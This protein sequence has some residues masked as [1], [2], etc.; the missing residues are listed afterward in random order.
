[1]QHLFFLVESELHQQVKRMVEANGGDVAPWLRQMLR[2]VSVADFP[3]SWHAGDVPRRKVSGDR[4]HDSQAYGKRFML[5]LD[6]RTWARLEGLA[7]HFDKSNAEIIRQLIAQGTPE[8]FPKSWQLA[9]AERCA[10]DAPPAGHGAP[11]R[12]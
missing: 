8:V 2:A 6:E 9:A 7:R 11:K 4:S 1:V 10:Q 5:R 3:A 12:V